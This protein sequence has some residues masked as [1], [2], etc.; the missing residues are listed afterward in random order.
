MTDRNIADKAVAL[1]EQKPK[2]CNCAQAVVKAF[3]RDDLFET[4]NSCGGGRAPEELCGALYGA[5]MVL[6]EDRREEF[7]EQFRTAAGDVLCR[8]IRR[9][10]KT[11]CAQCVRIAAEILRQQTENTDEKKTF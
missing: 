10:G 5:L 6:P 11:S 3:G 4:M 9:E 7:K 1:F 8:P 2:T